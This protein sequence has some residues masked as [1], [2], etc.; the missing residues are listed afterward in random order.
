MKVILINKSAVNKARENDYFVNIT[1]KM[2]TTTMTDMK[3]RDQ[4]F[5]S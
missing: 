3:Y 4:T 5:Q 1:E 2:K